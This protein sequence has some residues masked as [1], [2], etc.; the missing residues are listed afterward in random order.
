VFDALARGGGGG[1]GQA[2][3]LELLLE[4]VLG[5]GFA[6]DEDD[7]V[8]D[9]VVLVGVG[10]EAVEHHHLALRSRST[11]K[12][13]TRG[14]R[15]TS[16]RPRVCCAW[17]PTIST[18]FSRLD[19]G[20]RWWSTR[21]PSH[22]PLAEMITAGSACRR[23]GLGV[24]DVL[25]VAQPVELEGRV[26]AGEHRVRVSSSK[27]SG[28]ILKISVIFAVRGESMN[29]GIRGSAPLRRRCL[30]GVDDL[31]RALEREGGD[32]HLAAAGEGALDDSARSSS[33]LAMGSCSRSP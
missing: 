21:P 13:R 25:D 2:G 6:V 8:V 12:M 14:R 23:S 19:G 5:L 33:I 10:A 32:D 17:K 3:V 27:H 20:A 18:V 11:P 16:R 28:C 31:L 9:E 29:T 1:G 7:R 4:R 30:Q 22:I 24:L 15:S 26:V